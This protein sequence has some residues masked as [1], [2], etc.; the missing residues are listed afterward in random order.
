MQHVDLTGG[1]NKATTCV[2]ISTLLLYTRTQ[3][4]KMYTG[5]A[6]SRVCVRVHCTVGAVGTEAM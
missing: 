4:K 5:V 3:F 2:C 1:R 6:V